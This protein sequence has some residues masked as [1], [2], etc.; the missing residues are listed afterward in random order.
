MLKNSI[1]F[2]ANLTTL[3]YS[4]YMCTADQH[5]KYAQSELY[6]YKPSSTSPFRNYNIICRKRFG[7]WPNPKTVFLVMDFFIYG[8]NCCQTFLADLPTW[9]VSLGPKLH[10]GV[11]FFGTWPF[12]I[13]KSSHQ[14]LSNEGSD[15]ILSSLEVEVTTISE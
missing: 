15:F 12:L 10:P 1:T 7:K 6:P 2:P 14:D 3:H 9:G 11:G 4:T 13:L 8:R 5:H